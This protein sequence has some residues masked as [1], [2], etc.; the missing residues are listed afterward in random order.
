MLQGSALSSIQHL[1]VESLRKGRG[2][3]DVPLVGFQKFLL[4]PCA[5]N[6]CEAGEADGVDGTIAV[7]FMRVKD[8]SLREHRICLLLGVFSTYTDF[9]RN[10]VQ[11]R[12]FG[13]TFEEG[14]GMKRL[15]PDLHR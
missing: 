5:R 4:G 8:G 9:T 6:R 2:L 7:T 15:N 11:F 10:D 13:Q 14:V 3:A 12:T 1:A